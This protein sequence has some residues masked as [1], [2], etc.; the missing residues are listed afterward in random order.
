MC[1]IYLILFFV[2]FFAF[3]SR[4]LFIGLAWF[5]CCVFFFIL[6]SSVA[7]KI[8]QWENCSDGLP[9][10]VCA[11]L[12]LVFGL[13]QYLVHE[14]KWNDQNDDDGDDEMST[15]VSLLDLLVYDIC[16]F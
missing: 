10:E 1:I 2:F 16:A 13:L 11:A 6:N 3:A 9:I 14:M 8:T 4:R 15:M 5:V 12:G 7:H